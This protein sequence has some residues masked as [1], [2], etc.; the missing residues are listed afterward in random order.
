MKLKRIAIILALIVIL[1]TLIYTAYELTSLNENER[2]ITEIYDQQLN[3]VLYSV[4]QY[5]WDRTNSWAMALDFILSVR[6][7]DQQER[8]N[9]FLRKNPE[10]GQLVII[11]SSLQH[12]EY[13]KLGENTGLSASAKV[14]LKTT[15]AEKK[16]AI[17]RLVHRKKVGYTKIESFLISADDGRNTLLTLFF[18]TREFKITGLVV[19]SGNFITNVLGPKINEYAERGLAVGIFEK[20]RPDAVYRVGQISL[21]EARLTK[22]I[23]LFPDHILG[24]RFSSTGI[25]DLARQ[26]LYR[27]LELILLLNFVIIV[28]SVILYR[29]VR[30]E[31]ELTR[32]KSDFVSNV[33]H[34][35]RTPLALIRMFSESL[36]MGRVATEEKKRE[37]YQIITSET[38]RLTHLI[39]NILDFSRMEAGK[40]EYQFKA[41]QLNDIINHTISL[42]R[43]QMDREGFEVILELENGLPQ[44]Y[45]D[46]DAVSECLINLLDNAMKYSDS[47]KVIIVRSGLA[48]Q[49]VFAE[50]EDQGIGI[51]ETHQKR[52]FEKFYRV[53]HGAVHETKG[54]GLGLALVQY[55]V[56]A[57]GGETKVRS[58]PGQ[59]S[60]FRILFPGRGS[61]ELKKIVK[62]I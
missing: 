24:I 4:N 34:E 13:L 48:G 26:R 37:Y 14:Q 19:D 5:A 2:L 41:E 44:I 62:E 22:K 6:E 27:S 43:F 42:Y 58:K 39:N 28:V 57:H 15:L 61:D 23:W 49:S 10:I 12:I 36:E 33:S 54:S 8:L 21:T 16:S 32:M 3:A 17:Q 11:D 20:N 53:S 9:N 18:S 29:T 35:L 55:A 56:R 45:A 47:N 50:V 59:G 60:C 40:K 52:I 7:G 38:E 51:P 1:P 25:E 30:H 31:M 46:R